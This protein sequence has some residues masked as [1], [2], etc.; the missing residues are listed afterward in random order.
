VEGIPVCGMALTFAGQRRNVDLGS[1][2]RR[3]RVSSPLGE[4]TGDSGCP[5][6]AEE[7][8]ERPHALFEAHAP[9][10]R[11]AGNRLSRTSADDASFAWS[12]DPCTLIATSTPSEQSAEVARRSR[13]RGRENLVKARRNRHRGLNRRTMRGS[14][15]V[16]ASA[17]ERAWQVQKR[18][19]IKVPVP[20]RVV[21]APG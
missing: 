1:V 16:T 6:G 11:N 7:G 17:R 5:E 3:E 19:G 21:R 2:R 14:P 15:P 13:Y 20:A 12:S 18:K 8:N 4:R 10:S 9:D